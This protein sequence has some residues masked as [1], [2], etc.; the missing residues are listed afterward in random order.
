MGNHKQGL[1]D[2]NLANS[3]EHKSCTANSSLWNTG[4]ESDKNIARDRKRKLSYYANVYV[5][6][7]PADPSVEGT[8]KIFRFGQ[9]IF[10]KLV[11]AMKPEFEGD[12]VI[13]PFDFWE[14]ANFRLISKTIM[15]TIGGKERRMPNYDDSKFEAQSEFLGGVD[16][17]LEEVY[18]QLHSL[19]EIIDPSK[20]KS[21][22]D[23][24][25]RF[26]AVTNSRPVASAPSLEEQEKDL[27]EMLNPQEDILAELETSYAKAKSAAVSEEDDEDLQRFMALAES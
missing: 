19:A 25:K 6:S 24:E 26:N 18:N 13:Q 16:A 3:R 21:Y 17:K 5:V 22:D 11:A 1:P 23:L 15:T 27:D 7:N 12:A 9:K 20:F 14:G 8:V 10:D 4:N 2:A